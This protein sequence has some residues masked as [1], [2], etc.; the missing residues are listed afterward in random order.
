MT[1]ELLQ[2][3]QS[4]SFMWIYKISHTIIFKFQNLLLLKYAI[5]CY[6]RLLRKENRR[7]FNEHFQCQFLT[8][9]KEGEGGFRFRFAGK[10]G[11]GEVEGEKE[12]LFLKSY[13]SFQ[14]ENSFKSH[15]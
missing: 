3:D 1:Y 14:H 7:L 5:N 10:H 11:G 8:N 2:M 13:L 12:F 15:K 9:K 4:K 6:Y